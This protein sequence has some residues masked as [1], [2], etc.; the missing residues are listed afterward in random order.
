MTLYQALVD[1]GRVQIL[2]DKLHK[3]PLGSPEVTNSFF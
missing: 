1:D 3:S 2:I